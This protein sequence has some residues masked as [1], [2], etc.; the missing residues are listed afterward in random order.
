MTDSAAP[1]QPEA[2]ATD[3]VTPV[4]TQPIELSTDSATSNEAVVPDGIVPPDVQAAAEME[5]EGAPP[6][7]AEAPTDIATIHPEPVS[8]EEV[9]A[10]TITVRSARTIPGDEAVVAL[11]IGGGSWHFKD[12]VELYRFIDDLLAAGRAA[13]G[14]NHGGLYREQPSA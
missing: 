1:E 2:P 7:I 14:P 8:S 5:S 12:G 4:A 11:E 6:P 3:P 13:F 10:Q 9:D